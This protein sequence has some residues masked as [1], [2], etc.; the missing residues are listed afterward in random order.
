MPSKSV[1]RMAAPPPLLLP[2]PMPG[3]GPPILPRSFMAAYFTVPC[4]FT[5][6]FKGAGRSFFDSCWKVHYW[7][8]LPIAI[9]RHKMILVLSLLDT[10]QWVIQPFINLL[11]SL[12]PSTSSGLGV[13]KKIQR[14]YDTGS[15]PTEVIPEMMAKKEKLHKQ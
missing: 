14:Y 3:L 2:L 12:L 15:V 11:N 8:A 4:F 13:I 6:N 9:W 5:L 1:P 7:K 10:F